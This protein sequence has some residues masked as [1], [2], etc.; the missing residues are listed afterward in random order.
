MPVERE[1][2]SNKLFLKKI[3]KKTTCCQRD[4]VNMFRY[5]I[6]RWIS[7]AAGHYEEK[8]NGRGF[9]SV[10]CTWK[11]TGSPLIVFL[12]AAPSFLSATPSFFYLPFLSFTRRIKN[13]NLFRLWNVG[14]V[15]TC[16]QLT[17]I[18]ILHLLINVFEL[19]VVIFYDFFG[20]SKLLWYICISLSFRDNK[21]VYRKTETKN[22]LKTKQ[23]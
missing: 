9:T 14:I 17:M 18:N 3:K 1:R 16:N 12:S 23:T 6:C 19:V 22:N 7:E 13:K 8:S 20:K 2:K 5:I 21:F 10:G 15:V 4:L 11:V